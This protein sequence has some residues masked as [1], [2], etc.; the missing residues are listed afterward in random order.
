YPGRYL[1]GRER[2]VDPANVVD[3]PLALDLLAARPVD[4]A[5]QLGA[6]ALP[7]QVDRRLERDEL[8]NLRH[9]DAVA[10][11]IADLGRRGHDHDL[12]RVEAR[13][14]PEDRAAQRR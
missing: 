1:L 10:V 9:V 12:L 3:R 13:Q 6:P 2:L 11:R 7:Q 5:E 4:V 14:D 8:P